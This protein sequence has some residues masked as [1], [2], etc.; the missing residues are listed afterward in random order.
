MSKLKI[1]LALAA[2][3][4]FLAG[5]VSAADLTGKW[6]GSVIAKTP[7]GET[8]QETAWMALTQS[9]NVVTGTAGPSSDKQSPITG[10]KIDGDQLEF[11]VQVE[12]AVATVRVKLVGER[13]QG[14]AVIET[15]DGKV[16][17]NLDLKRVQ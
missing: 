10:G 11:K 17:A 9:G 1:V 2:A 13:L 14:Q 7:D 6:S 4:L 15:P 12:D 5:T 16:T 8:N 3:V